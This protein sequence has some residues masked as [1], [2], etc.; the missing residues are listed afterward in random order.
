MTTTSK[1]KSTRRTAASTRAAVAKTGAATPAAAPANLSPSALKKFDEL[2]NM[3]SALASRLQFANQTGITFDGKRDIYTALGYPRVLDTKMFRDKYRRNGVARRL[4]NMLPSSTWRSGADLVEDDNVEV[5][6]QF[7]ETW[8]TLA[9]RTDA[10]N[11]MRK[12]DIL[13]QLGKYS[14]LLIGFPG[15][16]EQE[17]PRCR[18]E[19]D[20]Q[21]FR[22]FGESSVVVQPNQVDTSTTSARFGMPNYYDI[23]IQSIAGVAG[24][25]SSGAT[26]T[27]KV[28]WS[29]VIHVAD[30]TLED[31]LLG[32]PRMGSVFNWLDDLEKVVGSGAEAFWRLVQPLLAAVLEPG[33]TVPDEKAV[34]EEIDKLIHGMRRWARLSGMKLEEVGGGTVPRF[35]LQV[36]SLVSL[37]CAGYG[38]PKRIFLGSEQGE[39]ASSQDRNNYE[40]LVRDRRV[41]F[42]EAVLTRPLIA[43]L[44]KY[45][46]LP[47]IKAY[48]TVWPDIRDLDTDQRLELAKVA[49]EVNKNQG[50]TVIK[51]NEI[52]EQILGLDPL[53]DDEIDDVAGDTEPVTVDN[54]RRR[55][56]AAKAKK[57]KR[58][59]GGPLKLFIVHG[60][61]GEPTTATVERVEGTNDGR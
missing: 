55:L 5:T 25:T 24:S 18:G 58:S 10:W 3:T 42:A 23:T 11:K 49:A 46:A 19:Q 44:M 56:K 53:E 35:D 59:R 41:Q 36:D 14:V 52:R 13:A 29:R 7:E 32:E 20:I 2:R 39:K 15:P 45:N 1:S 57:G 22:P 4:V 43:R 60:Q 50:E 6:T 38:Y 26:Q 30:E 21:F 34:E 61:N 37:I 28:H 17:A 12:A 8:T 16:L 40:L 47:T 27:K 51:T 54:L 33:V 31:E 9:A 48:D